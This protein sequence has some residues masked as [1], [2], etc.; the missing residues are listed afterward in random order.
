[1]TQ[2]PINASALVETMQ[3]IEYSQGHNSR[4]GLLNRWA[5]VDIH[6]KTL[7]LVEKV[8]KKLGSWVGN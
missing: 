7:N 2:I 1:M 8:G 6:S 4:T 3:K 5:E